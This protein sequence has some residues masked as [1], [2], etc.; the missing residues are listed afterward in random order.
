MNMRFSQRIGKTSVRQAIQFEAMDDS[1][2]NALWDAFHIVVVSGSETFL[3]DDSW[4]YGFYQAMWHN[5]FQRPLDTMNNHADTTVRF[6]RDWYFKSEWYK[7]YDFVEF[8]ASALECELQKK[9][10]NFCNTVLEQEM[11]GYRFVA[12]QI[13]QITDGA[14]I[15]AIEDGIAEAERTGLSNVEHHLRSALAMLANRKSPDYRN[16]IKE[17]IS[18][19]EAIARLICGDKK[20]TLGQALKVMEE[21]V[22]LHPALKNG[23]MNIYGYTSA[24]GGIR[25]ALVNES[26][27]D[28]ADAKYMLGA[29]SAFVQ[30]L[31][32]KAAGSGIALT[33][34]K[35]LL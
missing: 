30:Y 32:T 22:G 3:M 33:H 24:E 26:K 25:H 20:A 35:L 4:R 23:F 5:F 18:A 2:R 15:S 10:I 28:F 6:I 16:S 19:V 9:Y 27:T 31:I 7:V 1:T 17:S 8:V 29:C 11:C 13:V 14:E 21:K 34:P 12:T